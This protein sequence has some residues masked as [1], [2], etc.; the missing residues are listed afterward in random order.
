MEPQSVQNHGT[1][2]FGLVRTL[3]LAVEDYAIFG[4]GPRIVRGIIEATNDLDLVARGAAWHK[5]SELG[6]LVYLPD[7][8]VTVASFH[9]ATITVGTEWAIG[10]IVVDDVIDTAEIIDG[11]PFARLEHVSAYKRAAS[12]PKD[13]QHLRRLQQYL[14]RNHS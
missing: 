7:W 3:G 5:A 9:E 2:L 6:E 13:L 4:S 1:E 12:R 11:L 10:D 14:E 8:K